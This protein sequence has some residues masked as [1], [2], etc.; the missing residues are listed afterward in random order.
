MNES[1]RGCSGCGLPGGGISR[2]RSLRTAFSNTSGSSAHGVGAQAF[3]HDAARGLGGVVAVDAVALD[4]RPL[5]LAAVAE[6]AGAIDDKGGDA[7]RNYAGSA[8]QDGGAGHKH[9]FIKERAN[10]VQP[11][12]LISRFTAA[13][14]P[15]RRGGGRAGFAECAPVH[16]ARRR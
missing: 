6:D 16:R 7:Q 14:R 5:L 9:L 3:E 10:S 8:E 15:N 1:T 11:A 4:D 13:A 12:R 2:P